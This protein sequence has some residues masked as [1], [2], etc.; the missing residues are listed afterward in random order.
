[1]TGVTVVVGQACNPAQAVAGVMHYRPDIV[2][3]DLA[4]AAED[5]F[6]LLKQ[7]GRISPL[8]KA[9]IVLADSME[10][11]FRQRCLQLGAH[12][13]LDKAHDFESVRTIIS[14]LDADDA[15][16]SRMSPL[17]PRA[18]KGKP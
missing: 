13:F 6:Q 3:V 15:R 1:M 18:E 11:A 4:V 14:T 7:I 9:V 8:P 16:H 5:E 12:Y 2:L 10:D 17:T